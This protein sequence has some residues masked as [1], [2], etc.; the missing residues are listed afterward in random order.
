MSTLTD[1][2][3]H[4]DNDDFNDKD[5]DLNGQDHASSTYVPADLL[6]VVEGLKRSIASLTH[7]N[8]R[9]R[10]TLERESQRSLTRRTPRRKVSHAWGCHD[11]D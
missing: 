6:N 1:C 9:L 10:L 5:D 3:L 4:T 7:E 11:D 2:L 8:A